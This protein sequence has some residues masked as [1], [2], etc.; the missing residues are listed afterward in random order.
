MP[1]QKKEHSTGRTTR[2]V[3]SSNPAVAPSE[4]LVSPGNTFSILQL[5]RTIGNR[6]VVQLLRASAIIQ[7]VY[8]AENWEN[9]K[10]YNGGSAAKEVTDAFQKADYTIHE[11]DGVIIGALKKSDL[12]QDLW[13]HASGDNTQG[14]QGD[15]DRKIQAAKNWLIQWA[16]Q[17]KKGSSTNNSKTG[18]SEK[19]M[20]ES[21][22]AKIKKETE[23]QEKWDSI[24]NEYNTIIDPNQR[25]KQFALY[26]QYRTDKK[27]VPT[28]V[29]FRN[30]ASEKRNITI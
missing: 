2:R 10:T 7:R 17:N 5:Q 18:V 24:K 28:L 8:E 22:D 4:P 30:W 25:I 23:K 14:K 20:K 21:K 26:K 6:A 29:A 19:K 15:T 12:S 9:M 16:S 13:G 27:S 3:Y 11:M 1:S